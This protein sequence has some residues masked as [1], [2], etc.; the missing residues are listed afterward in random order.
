MDPSNH[1]EPL[2]RPDRPNKYEVGHVWVPPSLSLSP[3]DPQ[4]LF[5][6]FPP[7]CSV[8][9]FERLVRTENWDCRSGRRRRRREMD[10]KGAG[11]SL[12]SIISSFNTRITELQELVIGRNSEWKKRKQNPTFHSV[13]L[14]RDIQFSSDENHL[15]TIWQC[16]PPVALLICRRS[17]H[18]WRRWSFRCRLSRTDCETRLKQFPKPK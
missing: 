13:L 7:V 17:M 2:N 6:D 14:F 8:R 16:I 18:R 9:N 3:T 4:R 11:S 10:V 1:N 5:Q 15:F 12:D